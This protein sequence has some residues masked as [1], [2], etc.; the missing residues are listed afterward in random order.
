MNKYCDNINS[1]HKNQIINE[2]KDGIRVICEHCKKINVL[3]MDTNG[4]FNNRQYAKVYKRDT[5]QEGSN[6]YYKINQDKMSLC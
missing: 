2:T 5:V 3:R 6:L 1:V 4:R